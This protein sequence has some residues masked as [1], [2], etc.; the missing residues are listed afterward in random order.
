[1][2]SKKLHFLLIRGFGKRLFLPNR[3]PKELKNPYFK[4]F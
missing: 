3:R 1:M 4:P 2:Q